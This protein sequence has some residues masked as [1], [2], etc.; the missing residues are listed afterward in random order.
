ML[1]RGQSVEEREEF[2]RRLRF[3][4]GFILIAIGVIVALW[5]FSS[6]YRMFTNPEEIEVF[7]RIVP[8]TPELRSLDIEG[9]RVL[10]PLGL[11]SFMA[12]VIG[13]FL[14]L[15]AGS[16]GGAFITGG[17]RL[18]QPS[19]ARLERILRREIEGL[20]ARIEDVAGRLKKE[21]E[22]P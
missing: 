22:V 20:G 9:E 1:Q 7:Q 12:Y 2:Y 5:A 15:V 13:C 18:L 11:F 19:V 8:E 14:L 21:D 10:L 3:A 6:A 4:I 17:V 16:I